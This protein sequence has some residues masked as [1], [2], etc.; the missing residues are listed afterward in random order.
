[1]GHGEQHLAEVL[2]LRLGVGLELHL[3]ELADPIDERGY[4]RAEALAQ[5]ILERRGILE[6][7]V[8]DGRDQGVAVHAH[9]GQEPGHGQG[10][11]D[12]GLAAQAP[13]AGMGP[14]AEL[15]GAA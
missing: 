15:T 8:Q 5:I 2:G 9:P 3:R 10:V 4:V 13:L 1:M 11:V 12:V 7:V 6:H 14:G